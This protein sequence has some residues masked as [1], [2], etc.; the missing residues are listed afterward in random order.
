MIRLPHIVPLLLLCAAPPLLAAPADFDHKT[1]QWRPDDVDVTKL[2]AV[3]AARHF[4]PPPG[5]RAFVAVVDV[6]GDAIRQLRAFDWDG[7]GSDPTGWNPASTVKLFSAAG[8]IEELRAR[9][10]P[11]GGEVTF[12]YPHGKPMFSF[13]ELL[14]QAIWESDN[15]A[16]DRLMQIAGFDRLHG[17]AGVLAR[18]GLTHSAVMRAYQTRDWEAEGHSKSF[19]DSPGFSVKFGKRTVNVPP[20]QG[21]ATPECKNAACTSLQELSRMLCVVMLHEQLPVADRLD[22]GGTKDNA[23]LKQLR[24]ALRTPRT[25]HPDGTWRAFADAFAGKKSQVFKKG[26]LAGGW[27]SDNLFIRVPGNRRYLVA[28]AAHGGRD[29]LDPAARLIADALKHDALV[30]PPVKAKM[31]KKP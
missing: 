10:L 15:I 28:L 27:V 9:G 11:K 19:K 29:A 22:L 4:R 14:W 24:E 17:P 13:G 16:H 6:D 7:Q 5:F 30:P 1:C 31:P 21:A 20:R 25:Q 3:L 26:G 23:L 2:A 12:D 18:A 8:A